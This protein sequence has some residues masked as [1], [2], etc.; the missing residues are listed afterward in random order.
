MAEPVDDG[1][2]TTRCGSP[3]RQAV[4]G[5]SHRPSFVEAADSLT[6]RDLV[7]VSDARAARSRV[8]AQAFAFEVAVTPRRIGMTTAHTACAVR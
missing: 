7:H 5:D 8:F 3:K 6:P 4:A 1:I 2:R